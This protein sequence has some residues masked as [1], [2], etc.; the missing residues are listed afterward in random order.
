[1]YENYDYGKRGPAPY[2]QP[3]PHQDRPRG[4]P[5]RDDYPPE[6]DYAPTPVGRGP[7][8]PPPNAYQPPPTKPPKYKPPLKPNQIPKWISLLV[9]IGIVLMFLGLA[10]LTFATPTTPPPEMPKEADYNH[11]DFDSEDPAYED[12]INDLSDWRHDYQ[13]S[14]RGEEQTKQMGIL[15]H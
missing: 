11:P 2:D 1:M 12:Y 3:P 7:P 15:T 9:I 13:N 4:P 6:G 8:G 10:M 5:P 14:E